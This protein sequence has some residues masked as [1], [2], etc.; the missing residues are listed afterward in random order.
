MNKIPLPLANQAR[1]ST[2]RDMTTIITH[3]KGLLAHLTATFILSV[4]LTACVNSPPESRNANGIDWQSRFLSAAQAGK[5]GEAAEALTKLAESSPDRFAALVSQLD[6][7]RLIVSTI[8]SAEP[9]ARY[10]LSTALFDR[11]SL[12]P[13]EYQPSGTWSNLV[14]MEVERGN[15]QRAAEVA[16]QI[17]DPEEILAMRVDKRFEPLLRAYPEQLDLTAATDRSLAWLRDA[18]SKFPRELRFKTEQI[19]V[20]AN[21]GRA[22]EAVAMADELLARTPDVGAV[23][24]SYDNVYG[25]NWLLD[26][27]GM[28][29]ERLGIWEEAEKSRKRAAQLL[30]DGRPNVSNAINLADFYATLGRSREAYAA[31]GGMAKSSNRAS[32]FGRMQIDSVLLIIAVTDRDEAR[33]KEVLARMRQNQAAAPGTFQEALLL[34]N[35][36]DEAAALLIRRLRDP[37]TRKA[38][39]RDVQVYQQKTPSEYDRLMEER[40]TLL[41]SRQDVI[42]A[43]ALVG[44]IENVP[45]PRPG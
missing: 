18:S 6:T 12:L 4:A 16:A 38:A 19:Y 27:R 10:E 31:L 44:H 28:A 43:V 15:T 8:R 42:D 36:M 7:A 30:E 22:K 45:Q 26:Y 29:L 1:R 21:A 5:S 13:Y 39:L 41:R 25:F 24:S 9:A 17:L 20:L 23:R 32:P 37:A 3:S 14:L 11:R 2:I 34:T 40:W 35:N 33:T